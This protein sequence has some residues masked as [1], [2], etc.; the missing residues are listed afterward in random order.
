MDLLLSSSFDLIASKDTTKIRKGLR[1]IEGL[2]A[3]MCLGSKPQPPKEGH[4]R[5]QSAT[6][7]SRYDEPKKL[8]ELP[9]DP[10]FR[11]FFR[12][13]DGFEWNGQQLTCDCEGL[14]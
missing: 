12:L 6:N 3:S 7:A 8:G 13:Q 14:R 2:L 5:H 1:Q 9:E 10:A 4:R 11:E